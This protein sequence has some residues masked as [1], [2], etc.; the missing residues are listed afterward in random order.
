MV[1]R[2]IS[3]EEYEQE[4]AE[5]DICLGVFGGTAKATRVIPSKVYD[6][7]AAG[8]PII[9][10]DTPAARELLTHGDD[11][12]LCPANDAA[13][14][15]DAISTLARDETL[16]LRLAAGARRIYETWCAPEVIGRD[17]LARLEGLVRTRR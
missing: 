10:A 14:L 15:A 8:R 1:D 7:L 5:A 6:A 9:T 12:W 17:V 11:A 13:A 16:R 3:G 4:L 2:W